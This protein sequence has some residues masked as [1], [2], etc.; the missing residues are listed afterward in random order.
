MIT[1]YLIH[2]NDLSRRHLRFEL[3]EFLTTYN[4]ETIEIYD[5]PQYDNL[6]SIV[7]KYWRTQKICFVQFLELLENTKNQKERIKLL[8]SNLIKSSKA[9]FSKTFLENLDRK[10]QI[11]LF[12]SNKHIRAW[13]LF[14][15]NHLSKYALIFEDDVVIKDT[16]R[17]RL[18]NLI[19]KLQNSDS[20]HSEL[21]YYDLAGGYPLKDLLRLNHLSQNP[22]VKLDHIKTNTACAYLLNKTAVSFWLDKLRSKNNRLSIDHLINSLSRNCDLN[23]SCFHYEN[24]IFIHGSFT[25]HCNSWQEK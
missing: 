23:I 13:Q 7:V 22:L 19:N 14:N 24:P 1:A 20:N 12:V 10:K 16:S 3:K 4:I 9:L 8:L 11:E 2:N 21:V 6:T 5:Q 15:I 25:H 18:Q 17:K